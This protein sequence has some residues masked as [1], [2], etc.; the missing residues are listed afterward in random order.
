MYINILPI[1]AHP[2]LLREYGRALA[3]ISMVEFDLNWLIK[4]KGKLIEA[5]F[6]MVDDDLDN[7][8]IGKKI[9]IAEQFIDKKIISDL[10]Q[11]NDRRLILVHGISG[12]NTETGEMSIEHKKKEQPLTNKFLEDTTEKAKMISEELSK[13]LY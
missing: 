9:K 7:M 10:W 2:D 6:K 1:E 4:I 8:I 3:W 13:G 11:L 5:D 12:A